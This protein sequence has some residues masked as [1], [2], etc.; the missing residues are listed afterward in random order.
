MSQK[1][2]P[3]LYATKTKGTFFK[4]C[5]INSTLYFEMIKDENRAA[6]DADYNLYMDAIVDECYDALIHKFITSQPLKVTNDKIPFL[7]FKSNIDMRLVKMFCQAILDEVYES[8]GIDHQAKYLELKT[9]FM[10]MDKDPSPLKIN[11][12]GQKLTQSSIFQDEMQI[13]EGSH[14]K[15]DSGIITPFKEYILLKQ[16]NNQ[17][18]KEDIVEW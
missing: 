1:Q 13:L 18:S 3:V 15:I 11:K 12:V 16:E 8:T 7:I 5:S 17:E 14:Q 2:Y 6:T 9:M 10:Q 4:H